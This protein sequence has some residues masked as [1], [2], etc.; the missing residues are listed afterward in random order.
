MERLAKI[1]KVWPGKCPQRNMLNSST[2]GAVEGSKKTI[3]EPF[4][5][6]PLPEAMVISAEQNLDANDTLAMTN[7]PSRWQMH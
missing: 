1:Y 4:A 7:K 5:A 3:T 2:E 6:M